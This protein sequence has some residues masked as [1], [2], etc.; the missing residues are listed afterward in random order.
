MTG[1]RP[2]LFGTDGIRDVAGKGFL[3]PE[4]VTR[5]GLVVGSML[6]RNPACLRAV[7]SAAAACLPKTPGKTRTFAGHVLMGRDTRLSGGTIENALCEGLLRGGAN[8]VSIGVAPTP[9]IAYLTR[10]FQCLCGISI[11][12]SHNPASIKLISP[13]GLK[14]PDAKESLV[15]KLFHS[16]GRI[17]SAPASSFTTID[18]ARETYLDDLKSHIA[19]GLDLKGVNI[20][21]DCANGATSDFAPA[22]FEMLGARV[23]SEA[24]TGEGANINRDCGALHPEVVGRKVVSVK[25]DL[26]FTFDGDGS[27]R[28]LD[29]DFILALCGGFLKR[30][31]QLAGSTIVGTVMSNLGLQMSLEKMGIRLV[32]TPVGDRYVVQKMMRGGFRLGGE[33]SGHVVFFG[34]STTGDGMLTALQVLR[35]LRMENKSLADFSGLIEKTPQKLVNV[36]VHHKPPLSEISGLHEAVTRAKKALGRP[37]RILVR[38]SGTESLA[39]V[40][41]EGADEASVHH[42]AHDIADF[43]RKALE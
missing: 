34:H 43:I 39:R 11:T 35:T 19:R 26:G 33:Q 24:A 9:V 37:S 42:A 12:A 5:V 15:E 36:R 25:A 3:T 30:R 32:R 2:K 27:G 38:Y 22:L 6:R 7:S 4:N 16:P 41:V 14:V 21:L 23:H 8:V 10:R 1:H 17:S 31:G 29:G 20:V 28:I 40:M 13:E 18:N